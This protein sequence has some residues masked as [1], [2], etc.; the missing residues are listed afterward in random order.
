MYMVSL[1]SGIHSQGH[2]V[3]GATR[4][5]L[6]NSSKVE[7]II[8]KFWIHTS[9]VK[10]QTVIPQKSSVHGHSQVVGA[11][12]SSIAPLKWLK[13]VRLGIMAAS[14]LV[15]TE[16]LPKL[17]KHFFGHLMSLSGNSNFAIMFYRHYEN[18][19]QVLCKSAT[20]SRLMF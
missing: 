6:Y 18:I 20:E 15:A 14:D 5:P 9:S 3:A 2:D 13:S 17:R 11:C 7:W 4:D 1:S 19:D 16:K 12:L 8:E 10:L